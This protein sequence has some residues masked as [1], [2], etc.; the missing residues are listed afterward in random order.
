ME[1][2]TASIAYQLSTP[3]TSL[4]PA[5]SEVNDLC[6]ASRVTPDLYDTWFTCTLLF[7]FYFFVFSR[8]D[9]LLFIS[10][11]IVFLVYSQI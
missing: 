11:E 3:Y 4:H 2:S 6:V 10:L 9:G 7:Y 5:S 1:D 8:Q